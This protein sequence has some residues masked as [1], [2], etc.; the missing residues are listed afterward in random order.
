MVWSVPVMAVDATGYW[1]LSGGCESVTVVTDA[2]CL[3]SNTK[4]I[5]PL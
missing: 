4:L 5:C 2:P 1:E 3:E